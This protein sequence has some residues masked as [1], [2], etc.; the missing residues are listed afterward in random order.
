MLRGAD[1]TER[2]EVV[3]RILALVA[4]VAPVVGLEF[5]SIW[6][7]DID[8]VA[9]LGKFPVRVSQLTPPESNRPSRLLR[10]R[11]IRGNNCHLLGSLW[12]QNI[13]GLA[14]KMLLST[15]P[16]WINRL[17]A[18]SPAPWQSNRECTESTA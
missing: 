13:N 8:L 16:T 12:I 15:R 4:R 17:V 10:H 1:E 14:H 9:V 18:A 3:L 2:Y 11:G 6:T 5:A 7:V